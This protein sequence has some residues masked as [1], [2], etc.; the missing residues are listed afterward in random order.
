MKPSRNHLKRTRI[1]LIR[2]GQ[3][4][5]F[6]SG[7]YNGQIDV[8]ITETGRQQMMSVLERLQDQEVRAVYCSDLRRT[9][10]GAEIIAGGLQVP[11]TALPGIR[12]RNFG[13]WE[14]LTYDEIGNDYPELFDFWRKDVTEVRPP[15][16]GENSFDLAERVMETYLP[17]LE[18]HAGETIV[19]VAHGGV[20]RIILAHAMRLEIR[21]M[22]RVDQ[23]FGCLNWIDYYSDGFA[24]VRLV[25]S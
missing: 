22:F 9:V 3:V 8:P 25:N 24:H 12:E 19:V 13:D 11:Y 20:N 5:N 1:Y 15:G 21:Y 2:H 7:A 17:L 10:E 23:R 14:G 6:E 16:G 18:K 4:E